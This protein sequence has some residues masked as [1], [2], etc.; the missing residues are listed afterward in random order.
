MPYLKCLVGCEASESSVGRRAQLCQ[1][2]IE[3]RGLLACNPSPTYQE[4]T[5]CLCKHV[6]WSLNRYVFTS[7]VVLKNVAKTQ[8]FN[9][10]NYKSSEDSIWRFLLVVLQYME[11]D[12]QITW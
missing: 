8:L 7:I 4:L 9:R 5:P 1:Q 12:Y 11:Q 6:V 10:Y 2:Q 3:R